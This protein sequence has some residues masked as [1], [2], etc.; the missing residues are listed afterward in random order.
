V[1]SGLK[2]GYQEP[3]TVEL[4]EQPSLDSKQPSKLAFASCQ[5]LPSAAPA[6]TPVESE[7]SRAN[8]SW[9]QRARPELESFHSLPP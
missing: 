1:S 4:N 7:G 6:Q 9:P 8:E 5:T 2:P 3:P